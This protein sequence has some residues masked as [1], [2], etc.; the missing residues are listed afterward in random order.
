VSTLAIVITCRLITLYLVP[1]DKE[2]AHFQV[3]KTT[4]PKSLNLTLFEEI[5]SLNL[6]NLGLIAKGKNHI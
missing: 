6:V 2:A 1:E 3:K 4:Q 5:G